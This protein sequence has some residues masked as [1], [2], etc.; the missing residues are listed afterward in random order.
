MR[1]RFPYEPQPLHGVIV[2]YARRRRDWRRLGLAAVLAAVLVAL[3]AGLP[4]LLARV[5][6]LLLWGAV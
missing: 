3:L 1:E 6:L 2:G 4:M 5:V